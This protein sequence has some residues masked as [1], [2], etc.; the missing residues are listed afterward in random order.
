M[1]HR[2]KK[3]H[4]FVAVLQFKFDESYDD[5]CISVGGWLGEEGEWNRLER[6]WEKALIYQNAHSRQDQQI[7]RFHAAN[8]NAYDHEYANWTKDM[9]ENFCSRLLRIV[10]R[11][12][13][14]MISC[15][16][17]L[18]ALKEEF[19]EENNL[20]REERAYGFL[21]KIIMIDL[22][23]IMREVRPGDQVIIIHDHGDWDQTALDVYNHMVDDPKWASRPV[24]HSI[25]SLTWKDCTGLQAADLAAYET[26]RVLKSKL[27]TNQVSMRYALRHL[28]AQEMPMNARY[29]DQKWVGK[30][31]QF[32]NEY[33]RTKSV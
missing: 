3:G 30:M 18:K 9:S 23:R 14:G 6:Q 27:A 25:T 15:G 5:G 10:T 22:G 7:S 19:P 24:F 8:M 33:R 28:V 2:G 26:F 17:D 20:S 32:V 11:R 13:I 29:L 16:V 21:I 12:K 31:K 4:R 1:L